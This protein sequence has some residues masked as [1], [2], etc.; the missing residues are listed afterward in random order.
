V[1]N[2][3]TVIAIIP[4]RGGSKGLPGKNTMEVNGKPLLAWTI[5]HANGS[6]YIDRVIL[7]SE[8]D[9]II[10]IAKKHGC[11][12]PFV[13]PTALASDTAGTMGV[14]FHALQTLP[15]KYDYVVLLQVTSPLR[16]SHDIDFCIEQCEK[17]N[18]PAC[19]SVMET[20]KSPFWMYRLD[21]NNLMDPIIS[22]TKLPKRRQDVST[23][24]SI[25][26]AVYVAK[27]NWLAKQEHFITAETTAY[28]MPKLRSIDIDTEL[29]LMVLQSIVEKNK[30]L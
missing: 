13:R 8:D 24:Y 29:D 3:K 5:D 27:T 25:N 14:V 15:E 26:G 18:V 19:V 21:N 28:V 1:I 17:N 6:K 30:S 9:E 10:K 23:I 22:G 12:V 16:T 11:D 4:A 20:D 2:D 7:S